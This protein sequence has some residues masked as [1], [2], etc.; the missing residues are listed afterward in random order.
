MFIIQK[1]ENFIEEVWSLD[2]E[3]RSEIK[4]LSKANDLLTEIR[5]DLNRARKYLDVGLIKEANKILNRVDE[6]QD[7]VDELLMGA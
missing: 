7:E 2:K 6:L 3:I 5:K 1:I 4:S